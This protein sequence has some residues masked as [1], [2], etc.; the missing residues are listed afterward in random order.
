MRGGAERKRIMQYLDWTRI[1]PFHYFC[2]PLCQIGLCS[3]YR[4][5]SIRSAVVVFFVWVLSIYLYPFPVR[6]QNAVPLHKTAAPEV[7]SRKIAN[8]SCSK[9]IFRDDHYYRDQG[10]Y[11]HASCHDLNRFPFE[12]RTKLFQNKNYACG[13]HSSV[14]GLRDLFIL[15]PRSSEPYLHIPAEAACSNS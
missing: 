13:H 7:A 10:H 8:K 12:L 2:C 3:F 15:Q 9:R 6:V 5:A 11:R 14:N 4:L 1:F